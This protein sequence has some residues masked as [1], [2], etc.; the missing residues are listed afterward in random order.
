MKR[1][2][3]PRAVACI[4]PSCPDALAPRFRT[5]GA[6]CRMCRSHVLTLPRGQTHVRFVQPVSRR[7]DVGLESRSH[8]SACDLITVSWDH[9]THAR[10][11]ASRLEGIAPIPNLR[12]PRASHFGARVEQRMHVAL[13]PALWFILGTPPRQRVA[14]GPTTEHLRRAAADAELRIE[15][16]SSTHRIAPQ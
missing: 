16:R 14:F 15:T 7:P 12:A 5:V 8:S 3:W 13:G 1:I 2:G 10:L 11:M 9:S 6:C 4:R